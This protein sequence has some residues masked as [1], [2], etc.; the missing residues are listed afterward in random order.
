MHWRVMEGLASY[1]QLICR[2]LHL[3]LLLRHQSSGVHFLSF[4]HKFQLPR[5]HRLRTIVSKQVINAVLQENKCRNFFAF[6]N[7]NCVTTSKNFLRWSNGS[8][9]GRWLYTANLPSPKYMPLCMYAEMVW[10]AFPI[11]DLSANHQWSRTRIIFKYMYY[12]P[13]TLWNFW[14]KL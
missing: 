5:F 1:L 9:M 10:L 7:N 14:I 11:T 4:S 12:Y 2:P 13:P 8:E 3:N 6:G